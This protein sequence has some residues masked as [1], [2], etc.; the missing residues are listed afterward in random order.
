MGG[1][2]AARRAA[3]APE[4]NAAT[5]TSDAAKRQLAT[6]GTA[7]GGGVNEV[8]QRRESDLMARVDNLLFGV[9]PA[10]A[11]ETGAVGSDV[12]GKG[13]TT[14]GTL[15]GQASGARASDYAINQDTV[16]KVTG[17]I[18]GLLAGFFG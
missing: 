3:V 7:R 15:S 17:A 13:I 11:R 9:A 6:S 8:S 16:G 5:A 14:A 4:I 2:R 18:S 12:L 10:A 1:N